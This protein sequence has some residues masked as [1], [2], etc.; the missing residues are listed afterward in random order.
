MTDHNIN[1]I[2]EPDINPN[3]TVSD[4]VL[5]NIEAAI[6]LIPMAGG[7]LSTYFGQI[8][9]KR[10]Q[11]RML[12]FIEYFSEKIK[13]LGDNKV[14]KEYLNSEEFAEY[15]A[16]GAEEAARSTTEKRIKRFANI[17][18][19]NVLLGAKSRSR[20]QS[21]MSFVDRISD[22]DAF[23][24]LCFGNPCHPSLRAKTKS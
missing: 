23:I 13:E 15:F 4:V 18:I 20:T 10:A 17:L 2:N 8:R 24:L 12:K 11:Q 14:D 1:K 9:G 16:Q 7:F 3:H 21:I 19:N 5:L 6:K 22:L